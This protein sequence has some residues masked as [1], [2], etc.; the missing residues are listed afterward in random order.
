MDFHT[1]DVDTETAAGT[2]LNVFIIMIHQ[3]Q[4]KQAHSQ[5][6]RKSSVSP[7]VK[8]NASMEEIAIN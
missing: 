3:M 7:R 8:Y 5:L 6:Q 2:K 1:I 4:V